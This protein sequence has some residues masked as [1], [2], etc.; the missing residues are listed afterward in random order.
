MAAE[1]RRALMAQPGGCAR[2][3]GL[4]ESLSCHGYRWDDREHQLQLQAPMTPQAEP[5]ARGLALER[6]A[7]PID[8]RVRP[9]Y[10]VWEIT[11]QCDLACRQCGSRAGRARPDELTTSDALDLVRQLAELSVLEVTLIGGEAYLRTDWLEIVAA[12]G[13]R[14]MQSMPLPTVMRPMVLRA[15]PPIN[16]AGEPD[17]AG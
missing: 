13:A 7:R 1:V 2:E 3:P 14:G 15:A 17:G 6:H 4:I 5:G 8:R 12:I 11:L 10:E 9:I 16:D